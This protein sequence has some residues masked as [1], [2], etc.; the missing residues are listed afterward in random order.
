[1]E[2]LVT[3]C[4]LQNISAASEQN[5]GCSVSLSRRRLVLF[6]KHYVA[7]TGRE[8]GQYMH[9]IYPPIHRRLFMYKLKHTPKIRHPQA[10]EPPNPHLKFW[11]ASFL[12]RRSTCGICFKITRNKHDLAPKVSRKPWD[13]RLIWKERAWLTTFIR[14]K[15]SLQRGA[16][17]CTGVSRVYISKSIWDR[18]AS[19]GLDLCRASCIETFWLFFFPSTSAV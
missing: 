13:P 15:S 18:G 4:S 5:Q 11:F 3:F 14:V 6:F 17:L 16:L 1:M 12:S 9:H 8:K 7:L 2:S 19:G 10:S